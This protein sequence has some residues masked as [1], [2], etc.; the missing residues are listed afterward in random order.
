MTQRPG[1][2]SAA[3]STRQLPAPARGAEQLEADDLLLRGVPLNV[4]LLDYDHRQ[5]RWLPALAA[6]SFDP[7]GLSVFVARILER[8][9]DSAADVPGRGLDPGA[10]G[11]VFAAINEDLEEVGYST[12]HTPN[13]DTPIGYAHGSVERPAAMSNS[14]HKAARRRLAPK[15]MLVVGNLDE[16]P[17]PPP[18]A[19]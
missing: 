12:R 6:M 17:T 16:F 8:K 5:G 4:N 19:A 10:R 1:Q 2:R 11:A 18:P 7:D 14:D 9:G 13:D 3:P 15:M